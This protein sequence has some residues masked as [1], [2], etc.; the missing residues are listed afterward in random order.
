MRYLAVA[1]VLAAGVAVGVAA[2]VVGPAMRARLVRSWSR[3][4]M[5]AV[6]V[7]LSMPDGD[8][9]LA[10]GPRG[11]LVVANHVSWLDGIAL[12]AVEPVGVLVKHEVSRW[13]IIGAL[14]RRL[15]GRYIDR[16]GLRQLPAV[17]AQL[18][19]GLRAGES[20]LVFPEGTTWCG[21]ASGRF[22]PATFQAALDA[23]AVVRPVALR[24]QLADGATTTAPAFLGEESLW[25]SLRRI[26]ATRGLIV[27]ICP[28]EAVPAVG[29]RRWLARTVQATVD[30]DVLSPYPGVDQVTRPRE[31]SHA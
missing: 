24:Y 6:G 16:A 2:P 28:H 15:G 14:V 11:T 21:I 18:A 4:M 1:R 12:L 27:T 25:T 26:I 9:L 22:R 17:V 5:A 3:G 23:G 31:R 20:T 7:R 13:P 10:A 8:T 30:R 19:R 29:D